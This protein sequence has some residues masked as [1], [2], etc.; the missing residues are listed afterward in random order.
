MLTR[1]ENRPLSR[2][3]GQILSYCAVGLSAE[4]IGDLLYRSP[5]TV[6]KTIANI[7]LKTGL[8][9]VAE[10]VAFYYCTKIGQD[11]HEFKRQIIAGGLVVIFFICE[12]SLHTF[13]M[14]TCRNR[15]QYR[16]E[17]CRARREDIELTI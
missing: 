8:Q 6:R 5:E 7:K 1:A 15:R 3:E 14:R 9:K 17:E 11:F 16:T 4:E 2:R 12:I 10:L 13:D